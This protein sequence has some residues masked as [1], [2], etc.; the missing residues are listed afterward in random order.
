MAKARCF[1]LGPTGG[2]DKTVTG[3]AAVGRV[4]GDR[5]H[6]HLDVRYTSS[7]PHSDDQRE[8]EKLERVKG[9]FNVG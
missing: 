4:T 6:E 7:F 2:A 3:S 9:A 5:P 1:R 8:W